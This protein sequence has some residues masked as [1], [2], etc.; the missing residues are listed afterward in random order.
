ARGVAVAPG[1]RTQRPVRL[2]LQQRD[3]RL[4][5]ASD[6]L[7]LEICIVMQDDR[8]LVSIGDYMVVGHDIARRID[9]EA[10]TERGSL[11]R[12]RLGASAFRRAAVEKVAKELLERRA[13]W[14]LRDLGASSFAAPVGLQRLRR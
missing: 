14:K 1:C 7:G 8:N 13:R 12:L 3:I 9:D 5:I 4:G 10:R 2:D 6:Q 11:A